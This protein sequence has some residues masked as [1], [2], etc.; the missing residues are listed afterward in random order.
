L[1]PSTW[2]LLIAYVGLSNEMTLTTAR[3]LTLF[4]E[5]HLMVE[6]MTMRRIASP[7]VSIR[8]AHVSA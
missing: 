6:K 3:F 2:L 4:E 8:L 7:V 5:F 1:R